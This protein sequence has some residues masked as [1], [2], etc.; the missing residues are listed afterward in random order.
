MKETKKKHHTPLDVEAFDSIE[1]E[2][3][4][5]LTHLGEN[6]SRQGLIKTPHRVAAS[7]RFLTSGNHKS[8]A[9]IAH[10]AIFD[11]ETDGLV[12]QKDIEFYSLCEHHL[13]PFFGTVHIAYLPENKIIGLS[14]LA[15]IVDVFARRLQVQEQLTEQIAQAI[16]EVLSPKGVAVVVR[17]SHFCMMMRGVAKQTS[18]TM[19]RCYKGEFT[20]NIALQRE[21][22][23]LLA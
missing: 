15:R 3:A 9:E 19:T 7:L 23:Q 5:I 22:L 16:E 8:A 17:A 20:N 12:V 13:L 14:K 6:T 1:K 11:C 21:L 2:V 18:T 4:A 10:G